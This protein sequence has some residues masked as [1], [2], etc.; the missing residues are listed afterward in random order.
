MGNAYMQWV[1]RTN[2]E[3]STIS[4]NL[5]LFF[6]FYKLKSLKVSQSSTKNFNIHIGLITKDRMAEYMGENG[7]FDGG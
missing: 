6:G 4:P 1:M 7:R 5:A 3:K 2:E